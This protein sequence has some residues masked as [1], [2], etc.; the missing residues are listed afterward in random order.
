MPSSPEI[1]ASL[2]TLQRAADAATAAVKAASARP[3]HVAD[4]PAEDQAELARLR[5]AERE[6]VLALYRARE[7]TPFAAWPEQQRLREAARDGGA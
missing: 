3:G 4:W 7:G 6:A 1:P 5:T 2:L